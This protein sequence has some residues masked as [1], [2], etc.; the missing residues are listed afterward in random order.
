MML[1]VSRLQV[2]IAGHRICDDLNFNLAAGASLAI[3]GRNGAGKTTLL[4]T[5]GGLRAADHGEIALQGLLLAGYAPR[6][7]ARM[8]GYVPQQ[9]HDAF[10]A[11]VLETALVGRHPHLGR[12]EWESA[13]DRAQASAALARVGLADMAARDVQSLSGG[14]RQRLALAA[15]LVQAPQLMLLDEPLTHLDMNHAI[16]MLELLREQTRQGGSMVAVLHDPNLARRYCD[17]ALLLFGDGSW[18]SGKSEEVISAE[19]LQRLYG[20]PLRTLDNVGGL[21]FIPA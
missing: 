1:A 5:L 20:H 15:L 11:S 21:W 4:A 12:W 6:A 3:L 7:L 16:A 17:H 10:A 8:R 19:S 18:T 9:Q 14:E 13:D 2:S